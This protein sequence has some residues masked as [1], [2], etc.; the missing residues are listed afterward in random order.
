MLR[1]IRQTDWGAM[2]NLVSPKFFE[3]LE[4]RAL[5]TEVSALMTGF[6]DQKRFRRVVDDRAAAL[7][8]MGIDLVEN[9]N[10]GAEESPAE[11]GQKLVELYFWQVFARD[12]CLLD[13]RSTRLRGKDGRM[14]WRPARVYTTW[15]PTFISGLRQLYASFY[16]GD[17]AGFH[18]ALAQLDLSDAAD[19]FAEHFGGDEQHAVRFEL[20][21]FQ[22]VFH[23]VFTITLE[24]G[25][26]LHPNFVSFGVYLGALYENLS[27]FD[28]P[29]D[30]RAA[31][32]KAR[33]RL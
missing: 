12:T 11:Y 22:R 17:E 18:G 16:D 29:F 1:L 4:P 8:T 6:R 21:A 25:K 30:V 13:L 33:A 2:L 19:V 3:V 32:E 27:R 20:D 5:R 14:R 31:V 24:N 23:Q 7:H 28:M 10:R 15:D 9:L 26:R